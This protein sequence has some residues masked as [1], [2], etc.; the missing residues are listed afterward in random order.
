MDMRQPH[1][2]AACN[3]P[4][5]GENHTPGFSF[6]GGDMAIRAIIFIDGNNWY[7]R[8]KEVGVRNTFNLDYKKISE[9]LVGS[10]R[11]WIGTRFYIGQV[12]VRQGA[13]VYADH[14]RFV[15]GLI[16]T[17]PRITVHQGRMEPRFEENEAAKQLLRYVHGLTMKINSQVFQELVALAKTYEKIQVWVEKAVDV[18]LA[19]DMVVMAI[20]DEYDA[21]YI[22]SADGDFTGA[23][24]FVRSLGKKKVYAASPG[25]GAQLAA[26]VDSF[27]HIPRGWV[28]D[29]YK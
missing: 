5:S 1:G 22:L 10:A 3:P 4:G 14:R 27:I 25:Q 9:K 7:H 15:D 20:R 23:V 2:A 12:D 19:I 24:E 28:S 17:D 8:L 26:A 11:N 13:K 6:L 18:Q 21:A 29:C 16:K